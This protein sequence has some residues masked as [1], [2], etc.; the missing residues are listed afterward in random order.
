MPQ[1]RIEES[2]PDWYKGAGPIYQIHNDAGPIRRLFW[3]YEPTAKAVCNDLNKGLALLA[4]F[5]F[6]LQGKLHTAQGPIQFAQDDDVVYFFEEEKLP[7]ADQGA[8]STEEKRAILTK[9]GYSE[10]I[11]H[12]DAIPEFK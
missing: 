2:R 6:K 9:N 5:S 11:I 1:Y 10:I 3:D 7:P 4:D 8:Q 12:W